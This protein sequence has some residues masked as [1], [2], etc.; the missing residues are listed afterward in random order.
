MRKY[1]LL[2]SIFMFL[3]FSAFTFAE[4]TTA[5]VIE[6]EIYITSTHFNVEDSQYPILRYQGIIYLPL[7]PDICHTFGIQKSFSPSEGIQLHTSTS[8]MDFKQS[9]LKGHHVLGEEVTV[10]SLDQPL[11]IDGVAINSANERYPFFQYNHVLYIPLTERIGTNA[12]GI[13]SGIDY[14]LDDGEINI[15]KAWGTALK[16]TKTKP[17]TDESKLDRLVDAFVDFEFVDYQDITYQ[18]RG[19]YIDEQTVVLP[20][21]YISRAKQGFYLEENGAKTDASYQLISY[22]PSA[23]LAILHVDRSSQTVLDLGS[24]EE[25]ALDDTVFNISFDKD[26]TMR[27]D[28]GYIDLRSTLSLTSIHLP[29]SEQLGFLLNGSGSI[30]GLSFQYD[31]TQ[32]GDTQNNTVLTYGMD[33][34]ED[35]VQVFDLETGKYLPPFDQPLTG[36]ETDGRIEDN[37]FSL[38][39]NNTGADYYQVF[40]S[41]NDQPFTSL[42]NSAG[43]I[44]YWKPG[45]ILSLKL[46]RSDTISY[47]VLS[48][49]A[50]VTSEV[51]G[52]MTSYNRLSKPNIEYQQSQLLENYG[53]FKT[54]QYTLPISTYY[55]NA[56]V[57]ETVWVFAK[58]EKETFN[59]A[60]E[61]SLSTENWQALAVQ[62]ET[63]ANELSE[64]LG[65]QIHFFLTYDNLV[66]KTNANYAQYDAFGDVYTI[67]PDGTYRMFFPFIVVSS[68]SG[69]LPASVHHWTEYYENKPEIRN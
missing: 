38:S 53:T 20:R 47:Y 59:E 67:Q 65:A 27:I 22:L 43:N 21:L 68:A 54:D 30:I 37:V 35:A 18:V 66:K 3:A 5:S 32:T 29:A 41:K 31:L 46:E 69:E 8:T 61:A 42:N 12:F 10:K 19:F 57:G 48:V 17:V 9:Y 15:V 24:Y 49:K 28:R 64:S 33:A 26:N 44:W 23:N 6:D 45:Q 34:L 13:H 36:P 50:G 14:L 4:E 25:T 2:C 55:I 1:L 40:V 51:D 60:Y 52:I 58:L 56:D 63:I 7:T 39:W 11:Y 16:L 62:C